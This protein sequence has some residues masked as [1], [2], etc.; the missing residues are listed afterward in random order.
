MK[1]QKP[2]RIEDVLYVLELDRRFLSISALSAK[3]LH[4]TF[5][6][7]TCEIRNH[8]EVVTQVTQKGKLFMLECEQVES[9]KICEE[10][11]GAAKPVSPSIWHARIGHLPMRH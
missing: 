1:N 11:T 7:N 5:R 6:N 8:H 2:I 9:A 3:G 10:V 4:L